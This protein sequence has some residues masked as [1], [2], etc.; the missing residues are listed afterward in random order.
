[1]QRDEMLAVDEEVAQRL[2]PLR[3]VLG[4][5]P[6]IV[7]LIAELAVV[8]LERQHELILAQTKLLNQVRSLA[9]V[10]LLLFLSLAVRLFSTLTDFSES[11][12]E[13]LGDVF[14]CLGQVVEAD[15][16]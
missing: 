5:V 8:D 14:D 9:F 13:L 11:D 12:F 4:V 15:I 2:G 6:D 1:L 7:F 10:E 3:E 16:E